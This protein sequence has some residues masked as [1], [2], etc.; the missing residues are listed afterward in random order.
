VCFR[1][2]NGSGGGGGGHGAEGHCNGLVSILIFIIP[3]LN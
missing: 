3:L 2:P 1:P